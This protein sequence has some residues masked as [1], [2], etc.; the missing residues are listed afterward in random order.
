MIDALI[1]SLI[2]RSR[3]GWTWVFYK[4]LPFHRIPTIE[5]RYQESRFYY[6]RHLRE[7]QVHNG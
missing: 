1:D 7:A 2:D 6:I 3:E 4:V 5:F